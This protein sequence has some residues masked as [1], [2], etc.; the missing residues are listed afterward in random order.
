MF[1]SKPF[2]LG[3]TDLRAR[4]MAR[5]LIEDNGI[6]IIRYDETLKS[7]V[8]MINSIL[9]NILSHYKLYTMEEEEKLHKEL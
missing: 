3:K 6:E 8:F 2:S 7:G 5:Y 9:K 1:L 4:L